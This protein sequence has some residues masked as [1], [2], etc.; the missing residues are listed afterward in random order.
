MLP[1]EKSAV[2]RKLNADEIRRTG[3]T[4]SVECRVG[5]LT[6]NPITHRCFRGET[7]IRLTAREFSVLECLRRLG[8]DPEAVRAPIS[9]T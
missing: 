7:E 4:P 1:R 9:G 5:D 8:L 6:I 3:P 2:P